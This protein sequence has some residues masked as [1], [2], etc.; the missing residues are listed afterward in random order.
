MKGVHTSMEDVEQENDVVYGGQ[1]N[2]VA[3][4]NLATNHINEENNSIN[5]GRP[6]Q[7]LCNDTE[8]AAEAMMSML[9]ISE[10]PSLQ[11]SNVSNTAQMGSGLDLSAES[12]P[13]DVQR[14]LSLRADDNRPSH[15]ARAS[16]GTS[17][18]NNNTKYFAMNDWQLHIT[19]VSAILTL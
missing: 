19:Q 17:W 4:R 15:S 5:D 3:Y 13:S 1:R 12:L 18:M 16:G 9:A 6:Q 7:G 11:L 14:A 2:I 8:N 10:E